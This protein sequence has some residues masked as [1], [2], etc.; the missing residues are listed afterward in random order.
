VTYPAGRRITVE[1]GGVSKLSAW[2]LQLGWNEM[3]V[4]LTVQ[5]ASEPG[6]T[7]APA[8]NGPTTNGNGNVEM[9]DPVE[10]KCNTTVLVS[11]ATPLG[12]GTKKARWNAPL[13]L[14]T[15]AFEVR[16]RGTGRPG[17]VWRISVDRT[18]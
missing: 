8:Q 13:V 15:N 3:S 18:M 16:V 12:D 10:I 7:P 17:N 4:M 11:K 9:P 6:S 5:L 14:G 1:Q 2:A